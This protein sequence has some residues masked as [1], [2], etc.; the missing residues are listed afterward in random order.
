MTNDMNHQHSTRN[1]ALKLLLMKAAQI[2]LKVKSLLQEEM[3]THVVQF[4]EAQK[5]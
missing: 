4:V 3:I 1:T 5:G 2:I